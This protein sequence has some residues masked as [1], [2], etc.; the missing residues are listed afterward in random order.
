MFLEEDA[1]RGYFDNTDRNLYKDEDLDIPTY[2]RKG[3]K[4]KI[5]A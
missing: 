3:I 4:I 2:L 5:K 1:H